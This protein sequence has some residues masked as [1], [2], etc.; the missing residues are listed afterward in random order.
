[1]ESYANHNMTENKNW[2]FYYICVFLRCWPS[3]VPMICD[4][5]IYRIMEEFRKKQTIL[6]SIF[7]G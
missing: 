3:N 7:C 2:D 1:M 5:N 4:L 6:L